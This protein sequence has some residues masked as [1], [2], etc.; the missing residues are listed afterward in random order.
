LD[1]LVKPL[2]NSIG[3]RTFGFGTRVVDALKVQVKRKLVV[4]SVTAVFAASVG[5]YS[6]KWHT[7]LFLPG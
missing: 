2:A 5:Q 3:L 6:E 7:V 1:G 4:L